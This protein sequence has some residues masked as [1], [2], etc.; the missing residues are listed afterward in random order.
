MSTG[1]RSTPTRYRLPTLLGG[2]GP[3]VAHADSLFLAV[4]V[5]L[6]AAPYLPRL[7]FYSD[8]WA[9]LGMLTTAE[10]P[11]LGGL[12]Q[13][14]LDRNYMRMRPT[15]VLYQAAL[16][17]AFGVEPLGYHLVN[18]GV[19]VAVAVL[20]YWVLRELRLPRSL[21]VAIP[22]VYS[23]LPN[24]ATD[25]FWFAAFGYLFSIAAYLAALY[26]DLRAIRS[27]S[28][29]LW[30]WKALALVAL[31]AAG[32]G[33][34]VVL[35]LLLLNIALTEIRARRLHPRG[36]R[37][38]LGLRGTLAF[39]GSTLGLLSLIVAYKTSVA[40][41]AGL[42][43]SLTFHLTRLAVGVATINLGTF[44]IGLPHTVA[45]SAPRA[46]AA[47]LAVAVVCA[48]V[49]YRYLGAI[50]ASGSEVTLTARAWSRLVATGLLVMALGYAIFL[51]TGRIGFSSTGI[52]NRVHAAGALG[53]AVML[54]AGLGWLDL[55]AG[56]RH[57]R[58]FRVGVAVVCASG[59][60]VTNGLA[61]FWVDA[62][63]VEQGVLSDLHASLPDLAEGTTVLLHGV[64]PYVGPAVVFESNW[65]LAGA[66]Q[67]QHG[68]PSL[69]G[70]VTSGRVM[71]EPSGV[72]TKIYGMKVTHPYGERLLLYDHRSGVATKLTDEPSARHA[73]LGPSTG[74][75]CPHG[76]PGAGTV[77]LPFD[78]VFKRLAASGFRP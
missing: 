47:A 63:R 67:V 58:V 36:L 18:A 27:G 6:S 44:G 28:R 74:G 53:V 10:D 39:H 3:C 68:V 5:V 11:S 59:T 40:T 2:S 29:G 62:W 64:C 49:V 25:R 34:E 32:F 23:L 60:L 38:Q 30:W 26:A 51:S 24:Y 71:I 9:F 35:P 15:Q 61:G 17:R 21:A 33:Y 19:L 50:G 45:W 12:V 73:L 16:H 65:D 43:A 70:D 54:V 22:A 1:R 4:L 66:L 56:T 42:G 72:A 69:R 46:G 76:E 41:S 7:G 8:D 75:D 14:Q 57:K 77:F 55:R 37:G 48:M 31:L 13:E 52:G 78:V 20:L